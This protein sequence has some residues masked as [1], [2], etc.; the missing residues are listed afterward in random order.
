MPRFMAAFASGR[1]SAE[2]P[3]IIFSFDRS[4]SWLP[5]ALKSI[6]RIVGTQWV[7]VTPSSLISLRNTSGA[8]RPA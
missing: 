5:G 4:T 2:P 8:Y 6:C 3:T 1:G 7:K